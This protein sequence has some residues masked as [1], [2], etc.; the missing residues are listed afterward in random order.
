MNIPGRGN[1]AWV[2]I[3]LLS[4]LFVNFFFVGMGFFWLGF[5]FLD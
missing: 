3:P 1:T 2:Q 4:I 5:W